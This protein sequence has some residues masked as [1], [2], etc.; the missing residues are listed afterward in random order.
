MQLTRFTP[1]SNTR[2][3]GRSAFPHLGA[4]P[5]TAR[6]SPPPGRPV[7]ISPTPSRSCVSGSAIFRPRAPHRPPSA[8]SAPPRRAAICWRGSSQPSCCPLHPSASFLI[9]CF[10]SLVSVRHGRQL[11]WT[12][13]QDGVAR[14]RARRWQPPVEVSSQS[15]TQT[16][17]VPKGSCLKEPP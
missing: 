10:I 2:A 5:A 17:G 6:A 16:P 1:R 4:H 11:T 9:Y 14:P 13:T 8:R 15:C 12:V 7:P 3:A